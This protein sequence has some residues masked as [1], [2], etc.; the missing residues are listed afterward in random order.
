MIQIITLLINLVNY[1]LMAATNKRLLIFESRGD[2]NRCTPCREK[3]NQ[4]DTYASCGQSPYVATFHS[5]PTEL[6]RFTAPEKKCS[7]SHLSAR[8]SD[9]RNPPQFL[10]QHSH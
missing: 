6:D 2:L 5:D 3:P 8:L 1:Y 4:H 10:S 7:R 9:P